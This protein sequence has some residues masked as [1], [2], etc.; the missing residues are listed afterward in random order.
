[1]NFISKRTVIHRN[2]GNRRLRCGV[3]F[4]FNWEK[5]IQ[6]VAKFHAVPYHKE[7]DRQHIYKVLVLTQTTIPPF[8]VWDALEAVR[9]IG[10]NIPIAY[11]RTVLTDNCRKAGVNLA[12]ALKTVRLAKRQAAADRG[13]PG[14]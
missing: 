6:D 2:A 14:E 3:T 13:R 10:P 11:F 9:Q 5:V 7:P 8:A 12:A 1:M 4:D